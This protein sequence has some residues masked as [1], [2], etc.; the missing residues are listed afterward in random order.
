MILVERVE[1]A[2]KSAKQEMREME[3]RKNRGKKRRKGAGSSDDEINDDAEE[4][5]TYRKKIKPTQKIHIRNK[6]AM[7][8]KK[9]RH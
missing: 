5:S 4:N 3:E 8:S 9:K 6:A 7:F 2:I 1:E